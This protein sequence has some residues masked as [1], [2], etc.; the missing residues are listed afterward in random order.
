MECIS[1]IIQCLTENNRKQQPKNVAKKRKK[2]TYTYLKKKLGKNIFW[3]F[4]ENIALDRRGCGVRKNCVRC[5]L[6]KTAVKE[7]CLF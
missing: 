5:L 7:E 2:N 4:H 1:F 6:K 3:P